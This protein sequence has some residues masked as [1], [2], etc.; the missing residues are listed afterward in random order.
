MHVRATIKPGVVEVLP[1]RLQP[2]SRSPTALQLWFQGNSEATV[3]LRAPSGKSVSVPTPSTTKSQLPA[4]GLAT[5]AAVSS[6]INGRATV[7][8]NI[9]PTELD[10]ML[11]SPHPVAPSGRWTVEI[12]NSGSEDLTASGWI[13]RSDTQA[14]RRPKG[15]QS[16]FDERNYQRFDSY[17]RP[18]PFDGPTPPSVVRRQCTL[19]GIATGKNTIVIGGY[20]RSEMRPALYSSQGPHG[21]ATRTSNAP[22]WLEPSDDSIACGGVLA[23][24]NRSGSV[25]AMNGTSA[26]APQAARWLADLWVKDQKRPKPPANSFKQPNDDPKR[27]TPPGDKDPAIGKGLAPGLLRTIKR[28]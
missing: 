18:V 24:G 9:V 13:R 17:G 27:P 23:A 28:L 6:V 16:R 8:F 22:D 1:W 7:S 4:N 26:A 14:G 12:Y 25:A 20:R 15:R 10:P 21:S 3:T 2:G 19:S 5:F 11:D